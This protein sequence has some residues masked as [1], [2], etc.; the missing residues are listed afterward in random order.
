[1]INDKYV[2]IIALEESIRP[3]QV[4]ATA[5]L[6]EEGATVPFIAR[7]RKEVTDNLEDTQIIAIRDS[8]KRLEELDERKE[9]IL[10]SLTERELL[11][12]ELE[13]AVKEAMTMSK[14]EDIYL[15]Y[16]PKRKTRGMK[17]KEQGLEPLAELLLKQGDIDPVAEAEKF[18]SEEN[19]VTSASAALSGARDIIAEIINEDSEIR[20]KM[21]K[22]FFE[23]SILESKVVKTKE[24]EKDAAK[25]RDY[26]AWS[27]PAKDIPSHRM[28]AIRRGADEGFLTFHILPEEFEALKI[29]TK[30]YI[31]SSNDAAEQVETAALDC[32]KRLLSLSM[33]TELRSEL[34][35]RS[36]E[37]A[38]NVFAD[39]LKE[40]LLASPM[41]QKN[42]LAL[43]PGLRTG[44]KLVVLDAQGALLYNTAIYPLEPFKKVTESTQIISDLVRRYDIEAVAVGNGTGGREALSFAKSIPALKDKIV[45]MVNES[46]ASVYSASAVARKEFPDYDITVRG[47][48]SIGRRLMDPL[49]ELVKI[50]PKSIGVGQYQHDVDQKKLKESLDDV[51][52]GCVNAVGVDINTA[53]FKLLSY[54]AGLSERIATKIVSYREKFGPFKNRESIK[55]VPGLGP[56]AFE[57]CAGFLRVLGG[58]NPLDSSAV[59]PESYTIVESMAQDCSCSIADLM[60]DSS[61]RK[62]VNLKSYVTDVVG[63]PTLTDIMG[64]LDKPGRD[65]REEFDLFSFT[66]GVE[67]VE[68]LREGMVLNGVVTNVT[69]F[70]AFVDIGVHQ[71]GLVHISQLSDSFVSDPTEFIKVNEKVSVTVMEVDMERNRISLTMKSD[72]DPSK[73]KSA[74]SV[75]SSGVKRPVKKKVVKR[76][77]K[78]EHSSDDS[79]T[80]NPFAALLKDWK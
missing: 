42:T 61:M 55:D 12:P 74:D 21:R 26:F 22:F 36:D 13:K 53:S 29:L 63:M 60:K 58:D 70:G 6:L 17:A 19:E 7:Y 20:E 78:T 57:Q 34:K 25:Y 10:K 73:L 9:A 1:M 51:V 39:N 18:V 62:S 64:E 66:E 80:H 31:K 77:V 23:N 45:S 76:A 40:L 3:S 33:E 2:Q 59:H 11:T 16:R 69:A 35:K 8:L 79:G 41:G 4:V 68:D 50:E 54:V 27:E 30:K 5:K 47:A 43:D 24:K 67:H 32:Y 75:V 52:I 46:G 72:F 44:C 48:V 65:P 38:I 37:K 49:A 56:K 14:L 28:L 15:P 71:D